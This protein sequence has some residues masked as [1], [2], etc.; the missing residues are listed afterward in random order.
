MIELGSCFRLSMRWWMFTERLRL[1]QSPEPQVCFV[2]KHIVCSL[3]RSV[4]HLSVGRLVGGSLGASSVGRSVDRLVGGSV[5]PSSVGLLAF[6][7][8]DG[9]VLSFKPLVS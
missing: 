3:D 9:L 1:Y 5:G 2:H 7:S 4:H 6:D 8:V